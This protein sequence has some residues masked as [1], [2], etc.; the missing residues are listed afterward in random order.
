MRNF[1]QV[2]VKRASGITVETPPLIVLMWLA[3]E[4]GFKVVCAVRTSGEKTSSN[5]FWIACLCAV[6]I[7]SARTPNRVPCTYGRE[8]PIVWKAYSMNDHG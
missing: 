1:G 4:S 3:G 5:G 2:F 8:Y 7:S 6:L